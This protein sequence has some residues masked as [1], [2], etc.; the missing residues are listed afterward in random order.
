MT[1]QEQ[2][3][4]KNTPT[5]TSNGSTSLTNPNYIQILTNGNG[6]SQNPQLHFDTSNSR[7]L[8]QNNTLGSHIT[9]SA[10]RYRNRRR[11]RFGDIKPRHTNQSQQHQDFAFHDNY[12]N[13][14]QE[15]Q[16]A[17]LHRD[18]G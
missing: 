17:D 1:Q 5:G 18:L 4:P 14:S 10:N 6:G 3:H 16:F 12:D 13:T 9:N 15:N 2:Q 11:S 7:Y 8:S